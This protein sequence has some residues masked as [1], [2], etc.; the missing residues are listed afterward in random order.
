PGD[1][2]DPGGRTA[3]GATVGA[4]GGERVRPGEYTPGS[5]PAP[6]ADRRGRP[7]G[8]PHGRRSS[9]RLT[10]RGILRPPHGARDPQAASR[11]AGSSGRLTERGI[12]RPPHGARDPQA[13][14]RSTGSSRRAGSR[15]T[16][17]RRTGMPSSGLATPQAAPLLTSSL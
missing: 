4:R 11:S 16:R 12:L 13:A 9:G 17:R 5:R 8:P 10:E 2:G 15:T 14:S 3:H 6:P 7:S 1:P